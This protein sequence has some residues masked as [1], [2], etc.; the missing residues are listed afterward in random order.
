MI[1]VSSIFIFSHN[2]VENCNF[3]IS[4][5]SP[6]LLT[7]DQVFTEYTHTHTHTNMLRN[8][9]TY[10]SKRAI[11]EHTHMHKKTKMNTIIEPRW[12]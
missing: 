1:S 7:N 10:E 12:W 6:I 4:S 5:L 2:H 8:T 11:H 9:N 3:L